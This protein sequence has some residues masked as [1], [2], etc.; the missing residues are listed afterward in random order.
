MEYLSQ[1]GMSKV[2]EQWAL[3]DPNINQFGFGLFYNENGEAKAKQIYPGAWVNPGTTTPQSDYAITRQY[4]VI[5]YDLVFLDAAG[6]S[7]Q[8]S[9]VSD[10]EEI[11][12]RLVRFLKKQNEA[13]DLSSWSVQPLSDRWLDKVSGVVLDLTII[14]NFEWSNCE[15]PS[16]G[17]QIKFNE[18]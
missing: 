17:F 18:I 2:F 15:D 7:N 12:F 9:V 14:F 1:N 3:A 13:I 4:Q 6:T 8:N 10:C 5:I 16:Y 11:A